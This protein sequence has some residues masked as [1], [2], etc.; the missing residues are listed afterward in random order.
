MNASMCASVHRTCGCKALYVLNQ[1]RKALC[2]CIPFNIYS[3]QANFHCE[4]ELSEPLGRVISLF[5]AQKHMITNHRAHEEALNVSLKPIHNEQSLTYLKLTLTGLLNM[6]FFYC[7][8]YFK[9]FYSKHT[10]LNLN[11]QPFWLNIC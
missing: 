3:R 8:T 2:K 5:K 1:G 10:V 11:F 6:T 4:L 9:S 7:P